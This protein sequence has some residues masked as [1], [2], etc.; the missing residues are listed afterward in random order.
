MKKLLILSGIVLGLSSSVFAH[1]AIMNCFDNGD[2][3]VTCEGAFS[4][5]SS[6][7][8]VNFYVKQNGKNLIETKF[9]EHGEAVFKKPNGEYEAVFFGGEGH[10][11]KIL[12]SSILE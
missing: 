6:A 11:V 2:G 9:N 1:T 4:D 5:G 12:G 8:G 7:S 3:S 10:E